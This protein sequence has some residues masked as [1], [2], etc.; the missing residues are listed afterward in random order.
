MS[1]AW[2]LDGPGDATAF[3]RVTRPLPETKPGWALVKVLAFGLNRSELF[4]RRGMSSPDFSFPRVLGLECAG[5]VLDPSDTGLASGTR[6][7]CMMGG[8]GR[9]FDG[10]YASHVIAPRSQ[11]FVADNAL[12]DA[13]FGAIPETYNTAWGVTEAVPAGAGDKVLVRA[14][15]SALGM[16]V[17]SI[18]ADR[19]CE[20]IGTTRNPNKVA[21]LQDRS[22]LTAVVLDGED[23]AAR[24]VADH[25]PMQAVVDGV[26][27][28]AAIESSCATMPDGG[29]V[30]MVGQLAESWGT[31]DRPV[32]PEGITQGFTR[33]DLVQAPRDEP[34]LAE[35]VRRVEAGRY[36]PNIHETF[37]FS[38]LP[39]AHQ[40]MERNEAVGKLVVL[41]P[42]G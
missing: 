35:I 14:A 10:G 32:F 13:D 21:V 42:Q 16:A 38:D 30:Q 20:V 19:G 15:T 25:G 8:M 9:S 24:V 12:S 18:L 11:I 27:S 31:E 39:R 3:R 4:S 22:A 34:W 1:E 5:V 37:P 29:H 2:R 36:S 7:M 26:G 41:G 23:F 40:V 6:V 33:S 28:K 17:T